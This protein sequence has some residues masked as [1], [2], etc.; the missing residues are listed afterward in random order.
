MAELSGKKIVI[1]VDDGLATGSSMQAAVLALRRLRSA[2]ILVAVPTA[3]TETSDGAGSGPEHYPHPP[4][5]VAC[6]LVCLHRLIYVGPSKHP[7]ALIGEVIVQNPYY[8]EPGAFLAK[9]KA[10][11][12][13]GSPDSGTS[14]S[15]PRRQVIEHPARPVP[16]RT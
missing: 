6:P 11:R 9:R 2:R 13:R 12:L 7:R 16:W 1:V 15:I 10:R 14:N 5:R 8:I 3:L 4:C